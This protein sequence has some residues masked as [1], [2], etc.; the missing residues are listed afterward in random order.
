MVYTVFSMGSRSR[1]RA[2]SGNADARSVRATAGWPSWAAH[3]R[4]RMTGRGAGDARGSKKTSSVHVHRLGVG[5]AGWGSVAAAA[6]PHGHVRSHVSTYR[7]MCYS[8]CSGM[9]ACRQLAQSVHRHVHAA[10][11]AQ[12][13]AHPV[14][15]SCIGV[16]R[17]WH[18]AQSRRCRG[19]TRRR[20]S[21]ASCW[22]SKRG[23]R[24]TISP[25]ASNTNHIRKPR[26]AGQT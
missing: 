19:G 2:R 22:V 9:V 7:C 11:T 25:P 5:A 4:H 24:R 1:L 12:G 26:R 8:A 10:A 17:W 13:S 18:R 3:V 6:L 16:P 14:A 23:A 21:S 15:H 20:C